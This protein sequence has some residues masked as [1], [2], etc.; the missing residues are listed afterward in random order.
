MQLV[1]SRFSVLWFQAYAVN[2]GPA[3]SL[4]LVVVLQILLIGAE[5]FELRL[6]ASQQFTRFIVRL[7]IVSVY[8]TI[9]TLKLKINIFKVTN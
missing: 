5:L 8:F 1:I 7:Q 3:V 9:T 4:P 6:Q 2:G